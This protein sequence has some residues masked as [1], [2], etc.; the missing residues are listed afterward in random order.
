MKP[1]L[2]TAYAAMFVSTCLVLGSCAPAS[3]N[4]V[5]QTASGSGMA[6]GSGSG[7][8]TG[9]DPTGDTFVAVVVH[10]NEALAYVCDGNTVAEWFPGT[11]AADGRLELR[12]AGGWTLEAT[13]DGAGVTGSYINNEGQT[14][15]FAA[16]PASGDAGLYRAEFEGDSVA[17]IGGWVVRED[18]QQRGAVIGGGTRRRTM[19][20]EAVTYRATVEGFGILPTERVTPAYVEAAVTP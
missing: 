9:Q 13:L 11:V 6:V 20:L 1:K 2:V 14:V 5:T 7:S 12:S 19:N 4:P 3:E 8:Y 10:D 15:P 17:Y 16:G 18:G